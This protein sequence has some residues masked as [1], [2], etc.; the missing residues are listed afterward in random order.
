MEKDGLKMAEEREVK[1]MRR[2]GG[3][4][5][6]GYRGRKSKKEEKGIVERRVRV[7][8]SERKGGRR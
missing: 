3:K 7:E 4:E 1:T 5:G 8:G 2:E 6:K